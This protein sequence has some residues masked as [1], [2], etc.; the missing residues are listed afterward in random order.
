MTIAQRWITTK[1]FKLLQKL[2]NLIHYIK[3]QSIMSLAIH[4]KYIG[5]TNTRGARIKATC[6]I[7]K[8]TKWTASVSFEYG[9]DSETRHALAAKALLVKHAPDLHDKQLWVCGNT[10][11]NLGYVFAVYPTIQQ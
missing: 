11:D 6:T 8:N 3:G 1:H 5:A 4:T 9:A 7:D 2:P 10:L